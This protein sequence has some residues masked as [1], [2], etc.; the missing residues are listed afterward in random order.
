MVVASVFAYSPLSHR[1]PTPCR[2]YT[3]VCPSQGG[4]DFPTQPSSKP[5]ACVPHTSC[6]S[7]YDTKP[8]RLKPPLQ[9]P[10][11]TT[12]PNRSPTARKRRS[13]TP[14]THTESSVTRDSR[15]SLLRMS[16]S[17][18]NCSE[19]RAPSSMASTRMRPTT[20]RASMPTG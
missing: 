13:N 6:R 20:S 7:R 10:A 16:S 1:Y 12:H 18:R 5:L 4:C 8:P 17:S 15:S 11:S 3:D 2:L 14:P 9:P 19:A